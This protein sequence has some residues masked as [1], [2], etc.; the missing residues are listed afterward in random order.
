MSASS[1]I[2]T[3]RDSI[4]AS[5]SIPAFGN[6]ILFFPS[7][8]PVVPAP[9]TEKDHLAPWLSSASSRINQLST[10]TSLFLYAL[11]SIN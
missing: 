11:L 2:T 1:K 6:S 10:S 5:S 4:S 3:F 9:F 8:C 7:K